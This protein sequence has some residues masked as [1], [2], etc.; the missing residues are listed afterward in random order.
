MHKWRVAINVV[1][2]G[3]SGYTGGELVVIVAND[4]IVTDSGALLFKAH[5]PSGLQPVE[6]GQPTFVRVTI[7]G[8][9]ANEWRDVM[10]LGLDPMGAEAD[11]G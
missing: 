1:V 5:V 10:Y 2:P 9:N 6:D 8:Y 7:R 4:M 11:A 3:A